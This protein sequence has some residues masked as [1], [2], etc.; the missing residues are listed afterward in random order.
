MSKASDLSRS[1]I[2]GIAAHV[3]A[4]K[5]TLTERVLFY[6]G[7]SYKI[8]EVHDGAAHMDYMAE[9]QSHGITI[10]AAVTKAPWMDH[11][12]QIVDTPGHVDFTV[13]VERA[14]RI[15]DGC[16]LVLDGVRGVEPQTETVWRQR[17]KFDLPCL[18]F[19]N[20]MDR[21]GADFG[22]A[23]ESMRRRLGA[24]PVAVT[25]PLSERRAVL[26]LIEGDVWE[27]GGAEGEQVVRSPCDDVLWEQMAG[28][29][30]SLLL[31]AAEADETLAESVLAGEI[32]EPERLWPALRSATLSG[33]V[34][35]CFGGSALRNH[36]VQPI[37]D[38]MVRLL[39]SPTERPPS[40]AHRSDGSTTEVP[41]DAKGALV[42]LAFK[43]QMWEGRRHVFARIYRGRLH[44]GDKVAILRP[45]GGVL[46][47]Q[48]ARLFSVDAGKKGRIDQAGAGEILL[49]AGLRKAATGDTLC[50]PDD[51]LSLE[52][53]E[54]RTPVLS[55]AVEPLAAADEE[56]MLECL[57]KLLQEDPTLKLEEDPETGQRLVYGMG[58]LHLQ[59]AFERLEREFGVRLRAGKPR[60]ALRETLAAAADGEYLFQPPPDPK[61]KLAE[62]RAR[63][64]LA[65]RPLPRGTGVRIDQTPA[66]LLPEG[67][68]LTPDQLGALQQGI[69]Y[70][71]SSGPKEGAPLDDLEVR[72]AEVELFGAAST[73]EALMAAAS[74]AARKAFAAAGA[75]VLRPI[76]ATEVV[77]PQ[78]NLGTVLGD[79]QSRQASIR[80]TLGQGATAAIE[81]EVPLDRLLGYTTDLR[82]MTQGRGQFSMLFS[83]FDTG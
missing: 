48:V 47:E 76:M 49:L 23:M 41:M 59:I 36:G 67:G 75:L 11:S 65:A 34:Q 74:Q 22:K 78:E 19:I 20:K 31:A 52:P 5:T 46:H 4:G 64:R 8:G 60:V 39:P 79:L 1:R 77:V 44:G 40:L 80:D 57:D 50:A 27:F 9:E 26:H 38:G 10:T 12:I 18:C 53:I 14:M 37:L 6:A 3:D 70:A 83:R 29:R 51:I 62:R 43:V 33:A 73:P 17:Q 21:P 56:K 82:S 63:V 16:V 32:P 30:E 28:Y 81:C 24:E 7:V 61:Q 58:E 72:V 2:I 54:T 15:L 66:R 35:P 13:E 55:L 25:V 68:Q 71:L 45:D 69:R 42:A